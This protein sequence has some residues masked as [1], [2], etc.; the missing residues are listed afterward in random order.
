LDDISAGIFLGGTIHD[1]A[2]VVGAGSLISLETADIA[3]IVKLFRVMLLVPVVIGLSYYWQHRKSDSTNEN[4]KKGPLLPFFL[5]CFI[6]LILVNSNN[7]IEPWVSTG[8]NQASRFLLVVAIG[9]LGIKTSFKDL[10]LLGWRPIALMLIET[11][12]L[13]VIFLIY[14]CAFRS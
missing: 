4:I 10:A 7:F 11:I 3:V 5:I 6:A 13:A 8:L 1:V 2:Q 9:A 12:W 14:L